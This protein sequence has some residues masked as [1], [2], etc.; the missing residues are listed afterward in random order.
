MSRLS[1]ELKA[2]IARFR[3]AQRRCSEKADPQDRRHYRCV[4][5]GFAS[6]PAA[7]E[8]MLATCGPIP[9][10]KTIDRID[11]RKGYEAGNLRY[12]TRTEQTANRILKTRN[13]W[14]LRP[15]SNVEAR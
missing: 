1:P 14:Q 4:C 5:F 10:G 6:P 9:P 7:A 3:G 11:P 8:Y 12:A 2:L 15:L 13:Q